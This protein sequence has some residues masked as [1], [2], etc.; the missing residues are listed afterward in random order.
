MSL[1]Y[2]CTHLLAKRFVSPLYNPPYPSDLVM[3]K[4]EKVLRPAIVN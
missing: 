1:T 2:K 4:S 3:Y